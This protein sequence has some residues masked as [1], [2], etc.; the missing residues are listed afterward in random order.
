MK[1]SIIT[2]IF[3]ASTISLYSQSTEF[4]N[5]QAVIR[6]SA[7]QEITNQD[8][9]I[10]ITILQNTAPVYVEQ[11][12]TAT[13]KYG[14]VTIN[15]GDGNPESGDFSAI[16]WSSGPYF[17]KVE[18]DETGGTTYTDMGTNQLLSVPYALHA[19]TSADAFSG[20]YDELANM[21]A[22]NSSDT[23]FYVLF[24]HLEEDFIDFGTFEG[25]TNGSD[26][27]VI[28]RVM[29]PSGTGSEGG[30]HSF[31]GEAWQ[32]KEGD[33]SLQ[34]TTGSVN[35]WVVKNGLKSLAYNNTFL[36]ETW[37]TICLQ[38]DAALTTLNLYVDGELVDQLESIDPQD[39]SGNTNKMFWGG[40]DVDP[41]EG[42]GDLYS[43]ESIVIACQ[44][45]FQRKLTLEE[46]QTYSPENRP[47]DGLYFSSSINL[48]SVT[49]LSGNGH[50]GT[51]GN[52]PEYIYDVY[53]HT[54]FDE[55][56]YV[57][58]NLTVA[59]N[60]KVMGDLEVEGTIKGSI[61][62]DTIHFS[63]IEGLLGEGY[64]MMFPDI[65]DNYGIIDITGIGSN[66]VV[67]LNGPG[68]DVEAIESYNEWG[69]RD[70]YPGRSMEN[71]IVFE[72]DSS[73]LPWL[74][75][76]ISW[77]DESSPAPKDL[78]VIIPDINRTES[79]RWNCTSFSPD[80]YTEGTDNRIRFSLIHDQLPDTDLN[81]NL[82][83]P[84]PF[85]SECTAE[86]ENF[87]VLFNGQKFGC[88]TLEVDTANQV[89]TL[90]WDYNEFN[91]FW[92]FIKP[93]LDATYTNK[94]Q[95]IA[96]W[97]YYNPNHVKQSTFDGCFPLHFEHYTGF[98]LDQKSKFIVRIWYI[99][100]REA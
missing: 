74:Q 3:L 37:Y 42:E 94:F 24:N 60:L 18:V 91:G 78:A 16:D 71:P 22:T 35:I 9:G 21:P 84:D 63:Q 90:T 8:V 52:S 65:L 25:F 10:Q 66:D 36:E 93:Y 92:S 68:Y 1:K 83:L 50:N 81:I 76:L 4:F 62:I 59:G 67:Y 79:A 2:L 32:D 40:Q 72:A 13:N 5:Y 87:E 69:E 31:R 39:D 85:G 82:Q 88:P 73:D 54:D 96:S 55:D 20:D 48:N 99:R 19:K 23:T 38:Y 44:D 28:E 45:W 80:G 14:L 34:I 46:I 33:I 86:T 95:V 77:F 98:G 58:G 61:N 53:N 29:M 15:I 89:M 70:D 6:N 49:D 97:V 12:T 7:G 26:W 30:W 43:E 75:S 11:F 57:D 64:S 41:T 47:Q 51:N 17:I 27:S 100:M 56:L